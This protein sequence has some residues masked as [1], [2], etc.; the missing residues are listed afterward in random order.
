MKNKFEINIII[1]IIE[2]YLKMK[3]KKICYGT[4]YQSNLSQ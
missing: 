1:E 3:K 2:K 4:I